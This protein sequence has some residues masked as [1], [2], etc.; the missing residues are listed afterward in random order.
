MEVKLHWKFGLGKLL[1]TWFAVGIWKSDL[2]QCQGC[3]G[4]SA[5]KEVCVFGCQA[6]YEKLQV[7][8]PRKQKDRVEPAYHV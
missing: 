1:K 6:K 8:G 2:L 7:M 3:H 4:E 5:S